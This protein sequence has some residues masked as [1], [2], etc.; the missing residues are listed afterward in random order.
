MAS[1]NQNFSMW[2]GENKTIEIAV[3]DE[4]GNVVE[5]QEGTKAIWKL[6]D[7]VASTEAHVT[8]TEL[9]GISWKVGGLIDIEL[10]PSDTATLL[11]VYYHELRIIDPNLSEHV[12]TTGKVT[13]KQSAT[14]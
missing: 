6:L 1:E 8:K 10:T 12:I 7:S 14:M 13:I 5:I 2:Q 3:V 4:N 9:N 11:G